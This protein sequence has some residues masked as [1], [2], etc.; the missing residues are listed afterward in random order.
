MYGNQLPPVYIRLCANLFPVQFAF[1]SYVWVENPWQIGQTSWFRVV[2]IAVMS[3]LPI[4]ATLFC[5]VSLE[6]TD[7]MVAAH[8]RYH[9]LEL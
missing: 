1:I 8:V 6:A 5:Q 3:F 7:A 2:G 9:P 4:S